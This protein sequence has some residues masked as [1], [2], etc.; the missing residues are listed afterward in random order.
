MALKY[1]IVINNCIY[2]DAVNDVRKIINIKKPILL[3]G[4]NSGSFYHE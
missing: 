4:Y 2:F 1:Q 3:H